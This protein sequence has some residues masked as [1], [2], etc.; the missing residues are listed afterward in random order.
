MF[1]KQGVMVLRAP[2]L[3]RYGGQNC[4][5]IQIQPNPVDQ[6][7][8]TKSDSKGETQQVFHATTV[9]A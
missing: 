4:P 2:V 6:L 9:A 5:D 1:D 3:S 7:S 8:E